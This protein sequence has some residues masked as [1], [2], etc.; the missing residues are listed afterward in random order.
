M[1]VCLVFAIFPSANSSV[2]IEWSV[3]YPG[4][5]SVSFTTIQRLSEIKKK[6]SLLCR[7]G[8]VRLHVKALYLWIEFPP[9]I[10]Q[11]VIR[12][13][14]FHLFLS[15]DIILTFLIVVVRSST[16]FQSPA[17]IKLGIKF[18]NFFIK[19]CVKVWIVSIWSINVY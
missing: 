14:F 1:P 11:T 3:L 10:N 5:I 9:D 13:N 12:N 7:S 8:F 18:C 6:S 16:K 17:R 4:L 19:V 15:F 2:R